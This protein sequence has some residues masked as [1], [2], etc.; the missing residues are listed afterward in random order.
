VVGVTVGLLLLGSIAGGW[1]WLT[2]RQAADEQAVEQALAERDALRGQAFAAPVKEV[3]RRFREARA[4]AE[5]AVK[6]AQG[7]VVPAALHR[8]AEEALAVAGEDVKQTGKDRE[9]LGQTT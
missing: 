4:A 5:R 6:L 8:R 2:E 7:G 3:E 9:L 1:W